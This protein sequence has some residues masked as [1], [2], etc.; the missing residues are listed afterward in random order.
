MT[1]VHAHLVKKQEMEE[2]PKTVEI[3]DEGE[4]D[5]GLEVKE[6]VMKETSVVQTGKVIMQES[7]E[8]L[9]NFFDNKSFVE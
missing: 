7:Q 6:E 8:L 3:K 5:K 2:N 4:A 9:S 1:E